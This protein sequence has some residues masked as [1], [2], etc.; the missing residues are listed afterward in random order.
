MGVFIM[1]G[2]RG[3]IIFLVLSCITCLQAERINSIA[4]KTSNCL[5]CGMV[6]G[7]GYLTVK[8]CGSTDCCLSRSLDAEGSVDWLPGATDVFQG[9]NE[10]L[11][12]SDF[13]IGAPPFTVTAF[14]D[15]SDGLTLDW[16]EIRTMERSARCQIGVNLDSHS[17]SKASCY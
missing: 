13:E 2:K 12:C 4:T 14:H 11:E 1:T 6:E 10:M 8:V 3:Q 16:I 17:F 9:T 7:V 15:G 5:F